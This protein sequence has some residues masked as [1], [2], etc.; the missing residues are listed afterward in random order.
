MN[1]TTKI[2]VLLKDLH[3]SQKSVLLIN[4]L[5][6]LVNNYIN[7]DACMFYNDISVP[8][9]KPRFSISPALNIWGFHDGLLITT[10]IDTTIM[11]TKTCNSSKIVFYID[12][13]EWMR[14]GKNNFLYNLQAYRSP[15]VELVTPSLNYAKLVE[16]YSNRKVSAVIPGYNVTELIKRFT[17]ANIRF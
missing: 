3:A 12:D 4:Q 7:L 11:A 9:I 14:N 10:D 15:L 8:S 1:K 5:N 17:N 13:L 6:T 16:N 2:G